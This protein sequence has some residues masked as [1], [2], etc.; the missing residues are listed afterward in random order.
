MPTLPAELLPLIV[1]FAPPFSNLVWKHARLLL[2][3]SVLAL[4]KRTVTACPQV[5]GKSQV[6][7]HLIKR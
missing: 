5:I 4:G 1:V 2:I 6:G 7:N 3:G